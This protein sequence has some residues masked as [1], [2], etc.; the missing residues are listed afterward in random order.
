MFNINPPRIPKRFL[1]TLASLFFKFATGN[2]WLLLR[3]KFFWESITSEKANVEKLL[4]PLLRDE[5]MSLKA[6]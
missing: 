2:R 4:I 6:R 5:T 1:L 3:A